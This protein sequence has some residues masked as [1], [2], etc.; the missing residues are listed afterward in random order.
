M[1]PAGFLTNRQAVQEMYAGD[2]YI[3]KGAAV[4]VDLTAIHRHPA[5]WEKT[6]D[7]IPDRFAEGAEVEHRKGLVWLPF[8]NGSRQCIGMNF[9]LSE[10]RVV[11][12]ILSKSL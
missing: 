5:V 2:L 4:S 10:Q 12:T 6:S 11:L 8:S 1:E 3:S 9:S 7:F